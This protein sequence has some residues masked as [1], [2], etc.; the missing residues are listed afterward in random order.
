MTQ[1]ANPSLLE[2]I[3]N[4]SDDVKGHPF[5]FIY[6]GKNSCDFLADWKCDFVQTSLDDNNSEYEI[7]FTEPNGPLVVK[8]EITEYKDFPVV[9]WVLHF[10]NT[11]DVPTE[12]IEDVQAVDHGF[13]Q[14]ED[15]KPVLST[16]DGSA[17]AMSD[18]RPTE[19]LLQTNHLRKLQ[20]GGGRSSE[21]E[22]VEGGYGVMPVFDLTFD[23]GTLVCSV[24]WSGQ[25]QALVK[26]DTK[27]LSIKA[28]MPGIHL[29]LLANETIRS[30]KMLFFYDKQQPE[31]VRRSF[32][33]FMLA[34]KTPK[35]N[36]QLP[37]LPIAAN[38]WFSHRCGNDV[39]EENQIAFIDFFLKAGIEID[40]YWLDAGWYDGMGDWCR[41]VGNW[42]PKVNNFPNGLKPVAD[43][44]QKNGLGFIL[45]FEPERVCPKTWLYE[46]HPDWLIPPTP[47]IVQSRKSNFY[48]DYMESLFD[49]G[50]P[51]AREWF[52]EHVSDMIKELGITV[53]RQDFNFDPLPYWNSADSSDRR[54][55]T[56]IRH[57][58]GLY[59]F[60]DE[61]RKR[62][63]NVLIDNCA[64]G[65]RRIDLET[66]ARSVPL[67]RSDY[68]AKPDANQAQNMGINRYFP[69]HATGCMSCDLYDA[70]STYSS[71]I[72][73]CLP[74]DM[75]DWDA[76]K[77][78]QI[79]N[80]YQKIRSL[81]QGD[82]YPLTSYSTA[83]DV[84]CAYEYYHSEQ[85]AGFAL[86]FRRQNS[87]CDNGFFNLFVPDTTKTYRIENIDNGHIVV[88]DGEALT[89][90]RNIQVALGSR[91]SCILLI[92]EMV[93]K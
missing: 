73:F 84:W 56:Q 15:H 36:G 16:L 70:R 7:T 17:T 45:W 79:V 87:P 92:T 23:E 30:P 54:G 93:G 26:Y 33:R 76:E 91:E 43:H 3:W 77:Y 31:D 14:T 58:E 83:D 66:C 65:G 13:L 49:F 4:L 24:G 78:Q 27:R 12:I 59:S 1:E 5:S 8:A 19:D 75:K 37:K 80:E 85:H 18:F 40:T 68:V 81:F 60:W 64:S 25:W 20:S 35:I 47:A 50:N 42:T 39:S 89:Q 9:E 62:Y 48:E 90:G 82:F 69:M 22:A 28:C 51:Q 21:G 72:N 46:Q 61:L 2:G 88:L 38:S 53:Y 55:I 71:T 74:A 32:R 57:I 6:R 67:W 44:A 63:P 10:S 29:K 11:G 34:H 52:I 86:F 41:D